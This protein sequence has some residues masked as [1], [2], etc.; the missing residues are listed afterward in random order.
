MAIY[1]FRGQVLTRS[2]GANA[3]AAAAYRSGEKLYDEGSKK[4]IDYTRKHGVIHSEILLPECAPKAFSDR[5]TFWNAVERSEKRKDSQVAREFNAALP[6]ELNL[7]QKINLTREFCESYLVSEGM[8]VDINLHIAGK[9]KP[10]NDHA[11]IQ[12][13]T[14]YV[15]KEGFGKKNTA[16]N[17][18]KLFRKWRTG[19]EKI[20]NKHLAKAGIDAHIDHRSYKEQGSL[21]LPTKHLGP[22]AHALEQKGHKTE[23]GEQNRLIHQ[24]NNEVIKIAESKAEVRRLK[25]LL[26]AKQTEDE[27]RSHTEQTDTLYGQVKSRFTPSPSESGVECSESFESDG[28][29]F[30]WASMTSQKKKVM[31]LNDDLLDVYNLNPLVIREVALISKEHFHGEIDIQGQPGFCSAIWLASVLVGCNP[32][33]YVPRESDWQALESFLASEP[34]FDLSSLS[35]GIFEQLAE[36]VPAHS[37]ISE[38]A[39]S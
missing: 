34:R 11:H 28:N 8:I 29:D 6:N 19:W 36:N 30:F 38:D 10:K 4:H 1:H 13:A 23:L 7:E 27:I 25:A 14:R 17:D 21:M 2:K 26:E 31:S 22:A 24:R 15:T 39:P 9:G 12:S 20:V 32:M 16:W 33:G 35:Q 3:V 37:I 5:Q 18:R